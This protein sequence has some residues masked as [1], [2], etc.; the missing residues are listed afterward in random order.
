M[1]KGPAGVELLENGN[2]VSDTTHQLW[3]MSLSTHSWNSQHNQ[4]RD[5]GP[6]AGQLGKC[7]VRRWTKLVH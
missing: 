2:L 3:L 7:Q 5:A 6:Q 4:Q 1:E